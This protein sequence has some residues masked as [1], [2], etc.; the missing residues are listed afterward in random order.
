[1]RQRIT[2]GLEL[3]GFVA[4]TAGAHVLYG[5]GVSLIVGG[6]LAVTVGFLL[7]RDA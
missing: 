5:L 6:V 7:G 4:I 1:M 3:A 2:T